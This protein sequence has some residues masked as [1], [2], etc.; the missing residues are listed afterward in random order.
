VTDTPAQAIRRAAA[1]MRVRAEA[2]QHFRCPWRNA[3]P[4][5][6]D[7][8]TVAYATDVPAAGL[9]ATTPDYGADALPDYIAGMH[10]GVALDVADLLDAAASLAAP[11]W[12]SPVTCAALRLARTF[13]AEDDEAGIEAVERAGR[14]AWDKHHGS[15][16]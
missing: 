7:E 14:A 9:I 15:G 2:V 8:W 12:E 10:P 13:L 6:N 3:G 1:L 5:W 11:P 16:S 4:T